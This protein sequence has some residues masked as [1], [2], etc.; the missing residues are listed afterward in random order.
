VGGFVF[1]TLA[2]IDMS[3]NSQFS[4]LRCCDVK[5]KKQVDSLHHGVSYSLEC[6]YF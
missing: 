3:L 5:N 1:V 6:K 4:Y 2:L